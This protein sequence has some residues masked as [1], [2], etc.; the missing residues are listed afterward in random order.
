VHQARE[1]IGQQL[2]ERLAVAHSKLRQLGVPDALLADDPAAR[3]VGANPPLNLTGAADAFRDGVKPESQQH[4]DADQRTPLPPLDRL[5]ARG[6]RRQIERLH[7]A[8]QEPRPVAL[9][10][11]VLRHLEPDHG[12]PAER[13]VGAHPR[14]RLAHAPYN[15]RRL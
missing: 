10:P 5:R 8:P 13:L 12:L 6:E 1:H 4:V 2:V 9:G 14:L 7:D 3:I 11:R 15:P